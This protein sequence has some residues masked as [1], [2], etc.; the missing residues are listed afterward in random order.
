M[1]TVFGVKVI[2]LDGFFR[3]QEERVAVGVGGHFNLGV[4]QHFARQRLKLLGQVREHA[5]GRGFAF[6]DGHRGQVRVGTDEVIQHYATGV[7]RARDLG[8]RRETVA[9]NVYRGDTTTILGGGIGARLHR[10]AQG[11]LHERERVKYPAAAFG[12][13]F[14]DIRRQGHAAP[15]GGDDGRVLAVLA[16]AEHQARR[17]SVGLCRHQGQAT[18]AGHQRRLELADQAVVLADHLQRAGFAGGAFAQAQALQQRPVFDRQAGENRQWH[19]LI[20][21]F[22]HPGIKGAAV[23]RHAVGHPQH[24]AGVQAIEAMLRQRLVGGQVIDPVAQVLEQAAQEQMARVFGEVAFARVVQHGDTARLHFNRA[25]AHAVQVRGTDH[26][27]ETFLAQLL[28]QLAGFLAA[29]AWQVVDGHQRDVFFAQRLELAFEPL[30]VIGRYRAITLGARVPTGMDR[31]HRHRAGH[32]VQFTE[33]FKATVEKQFE[34][35]LAAVQLAQQR[36][37]RLALGFLVGLGQQLEAVQGVE[38]QARIALGLERGGTLE[39]VL[40]PGVGGQVHDLAVPGLV[41]HGAGGLG[42]GIALQGRAITIEL[43]DRQVGEGLA[44]Q[45]AQG[46][47]IGGGQMPRLYNRPVKLGQ[48]R[49]WRI[50]CVPECDTCRPVVPSLCGKPCHAQCQR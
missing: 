27:G 9:I 42:Q 50:V 31:L 8:T 49:Q 33:H 32:A 43:A 3:L 38:E 20:E 35:R 48:F 46:L 34:L 36:G 47:D 19:L 39:Q 41:A 22:V 12:V 30:L 45:A 11:L 23:F 24:H 16:I 10:Q 25:Q 5:F 21:A 40:A 6:N 2:A 4:G 17:R 18:A 26:R 15:L 37:Q 13:G 14:D 7:R 28:G 29:F 44:A 1:Q